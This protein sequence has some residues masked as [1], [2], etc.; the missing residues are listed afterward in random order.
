MSAFQ[1]AALVRL[2]GGVLALLVM[3]SLVG[4]LLGRRTLGPSGRATVE[5]INARTRAWRSIR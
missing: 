5:N 3:A 4:W 2:V 1:D